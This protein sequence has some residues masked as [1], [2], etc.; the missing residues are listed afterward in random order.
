[1][2][3]TLTKPKENFLSKKNL[4]QVFMSGFQVQM[5]LA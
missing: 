1:M 2:F 5:E 3:M 4:F